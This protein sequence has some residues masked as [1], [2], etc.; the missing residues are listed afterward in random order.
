M[1]DGR[2]GSAIPWELIPSEQ[3]VLERKVEADLLGFTRY[4]L[5]IGRLAR[6]AIIAFAGDLWSW[7]GGGLP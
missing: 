1:S 7:Y 4:A 5:A 6:F 2:S 3:S